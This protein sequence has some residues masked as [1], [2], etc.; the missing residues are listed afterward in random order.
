MIHFL[1]RFKNISFGAAMAFL[2]LGAFSACNKSSNNSLNSPE[3]PT[4]PQAKARKVLMI[5]VDGGLGTEVKKIA[6]PVMTDLSANAIFSWDALSTTENTSFVTNDGGVATLLTGVNPGKHGVIA[7]VTANNFTQY[8][9]LFSKL[10]ALSPGL[11]SVAISSATSVVNTMAVDATDKKVVATDAAAK[12]AALSELNTGNPSLM[13]VEFTGADQAGMADAYL[14]SSSTYKDAVIA[15]DTYIGQLLSA[16]NKRANAP[17][18]DWMVVIA[19]SK[20][21]STVYAP[22]TKPWSAFDDGRHNNFLIMANPRFAYNNKEK[23]TVFPYYGTTN[24]YRIGNV[25]GTSRR[26]AEVKDATKYNF[27]NS[28]DFSVQCKVKIPTGDYGYPSFLGKRLAFTTSTGNHGWLFFLENSDWQANFNGANGTGG[29]AQARGTR[30][31][32]NVWHNLNLVV[33]QGAGTVRNITVYTD[34]VRNAT[35]NVAARDL[36]TTA[37]FAVGWRDGSN[38]NDIQMNITDIRIYNRALSDAEIA[39][40]YCRTDAD[41]T[42]ASLIAFWPSTNIEYDADGNPFLRDFTAG[43]NHLYF[44]NPSIIAFSEASPNVC[45]LVDNVAYR[46]V[47]QSVDV[48]TQIYLWMGVTIPQSWGLDG[49]SWIPKYLDIVE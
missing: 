29:N 24:S 38:G 27:G 37:P 7:D 26:Y 43:A 10:K 16:L 23:P 35:T 28:G 39:N 1:I 47:P 45:P 25:S 36:N 19:S 8:P 34:G 49:Q 46:T 6:P 42:D 9:T 48:A 31:A 12:D 41:L 17:N 15:I 18:E 30:V 11:R 44:T 21:N 13:L 20:G 33:T 4:N 32:N 3:N 40:N 22:V 14:A 2:A 5:V